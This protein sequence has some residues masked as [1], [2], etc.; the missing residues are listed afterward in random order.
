MKIL[1]F[2]LA[3]FT[4][5]TVAFADPAADHKAALRE[6]NAAFTVAYEKCESATSVKARNKCRGQAKGQHT[7]AVEKADKARAVAT[8]SK[9]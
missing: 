9:S 7:K 6:A 8:K 2:G 4:F 3:I 5:A 1:L